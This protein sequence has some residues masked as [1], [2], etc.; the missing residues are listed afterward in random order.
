MKKRFTLLCLLGL[1]V[2]FAGK[3]QQDSA[4]KLLGVTIVEYGNRELG[5]G[6]SYRS[7]DSSQKSIFQQRDLSTLLSYLI[8]LG[9]NMVLQLPYGVVELWVERSIFRIIRA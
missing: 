2:S 3:A 9:F 8:I 4:F 5:K 1:L 6:S 7:I